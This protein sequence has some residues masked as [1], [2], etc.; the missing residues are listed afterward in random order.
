MNET[1][2]TPTPRCTDCDHV[3]PSTGAVCHVCDVETHFE[4]VLRT[5]PPMFTRR[6]DAVPAQPPR[7]GR[8]A[9]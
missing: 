6:D 4:G 5:A 1:A 2:P 9:S 8:Q 7:S 3:L